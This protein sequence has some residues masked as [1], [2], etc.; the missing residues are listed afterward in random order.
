MSQSDWRAAQA[1]SA[2]RTEPLYKYCQVERPGPEVQR[3]R[4]VPQSPTVL[5]T[6]FHW[7][8]AGFAEVTVGKGLAGYRNSPCPRKWLSCPRLTTTLL[9]CLTPQPFQPKLRLSRKMLANPHRLRTCALLLGII[10]LAA[11]FH[12]C[13]DLNSG[14]GGPHPC[15]LCSTASSA[16]ATHTLTLAIVPVVGRLEV[17]AKVLIPSVEASRATS[18]RAPP[19]L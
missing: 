18:P 11:Q 16:V 15:Q 5:M 12:F 9:L 10:F 3:E 14:P 2:S 6:V 19:S 1:P 7:R 8:T 13:A 4:D 17:F